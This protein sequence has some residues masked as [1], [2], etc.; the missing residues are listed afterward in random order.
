VQPLPGW[1]EIGSPQVNEDVERIFQNELADSRKLSSEARKKRLENA[2]RHPEVI[3]VISR[4]FR[5]N[6][7]VVVEVLL[8]AKGVCGRCNS[9]APFVRKSDGTPYL[10]IHHRITLSD[11]GEDTLENA[12]ALCP[13]CHRFF[14]FG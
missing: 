14:H 5:R 1:L 9:K 4:G 10:E 13:N 6:A 12:I 2:P 8:R 3:Q 7:D 11:G